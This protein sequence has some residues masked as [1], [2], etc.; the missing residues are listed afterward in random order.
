MWPA[1]QSCSYPVLLEFPAP[2]ILVYPPEAVIA[3][4]LEAIVV[5]GERNS[6]IKDFFDLRYLAGRFAF[7]RATLGEAVRRTLGRRSTPLPADEPIGLTRACWDNP[8]R[9]PQVRA[10]A[11]RAGLTVGAD[12]GVELLAVLRPFLLPILEDVRRGA[13]MSG[14]WP[15]GGPWEG[16]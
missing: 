16:A 9:P 15:P 5:L 12:P 2:D 6:R 13:A 10:F 14:T 8:S 3:E 1:A 11:R 7:H 4:K